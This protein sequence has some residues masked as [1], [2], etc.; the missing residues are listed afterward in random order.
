MLMTLLRTGAYACLFILLGLWISL[1]SALYLRHGLRTRTVESGN[2][3][4]LD[5]RAR[6][7]NLA[8]TT[9]EDLTSDVFLVLNLDRRKDRWRCAE[10]EFRRHGIVA[11]RVAAI[12]GTKRF[13]P[14][15][16]TEEIYSLNL[17]NRQQKHQLAQENG[18]N[19]GHLATFISHISAVRAIR[20]RKAS[21]A[22]IFED[23]A[24]LVPNFSEK[25]KVLKRELPNN[26]ELLVLS[27][28]CHTWPVCNENAKKQPIS[29]HLKPV[30][31]FMSGAGYC[32]NAASAA[33]ILSNVP[34]PRIETV[35]MD[36]YLTNLITPLGI[37]RHAFRAIVLP[38]L[39]PQDLMKLGSVLV[40]NPD[41]YSR[42]DS[43]IA[44]W[45]KPEKP[46]S[47]EACVVFSRSGG[48]RLFAKVASRGVAWQPAKGGGM[49]IPTLEGESVLFG[50]TDRSRKEMRRIFVWKTM[51]IKT[52]Q[53]TE[54]CRLVF[55]SD[56]MSNSFSDF[57]TKRCCLKNGESREQSSNRF[58]IFIYIKLYF[59][60]VVRNFVII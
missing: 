44:L 14:E 36:G 60:L 42:F 12:D 52:Y 19:L 41:C 28:Y 59:N 20:D 10:E 16:R 7:G 22:C 53:R 32:L 45:W 21:F 35:A 25:L 5:E 34:H 11:E 43:D 6:G 13:P 51:N 48:R 18:I 26:W 50:S 24:I 2:V 56:S 31:G 33:L 9:S 1:I 37:I 39:I 29:P 23:D 40:D 46:R 49:L 8:W 15:N 47:G 27:M 38:V 30:R 3:A 54:I 58:R 17:L 55:K 4:S 57:L